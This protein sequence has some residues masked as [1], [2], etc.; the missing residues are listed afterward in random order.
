MAQ[1]LPFQLVLAVVAVLP[2]LVL[3]LGWFWKPANP[4]Q[5]WPIAYESYQLV[6][7]IVFLLVV[8]LAGTLLLWLQKPRSF[9]RQPFVVL[10]LVYLGLVLL[11]SA[12][13]RDDLSRF[14][15]W[16]GLLRMDGV[17]YQI[18]LVLVGILAYGSVNSQNLSR[19]LTF[20][21]L[22]GAA[23]GLLMLGQVNGIDPLGVGLRWAGSTLAFGSLAHPGMAAGLL[24]VSV[25]LAV[26]MLG[27][28]PR[29]VLLWIGLV[30]STLGIGYTTN[31]T[32]VLVLLVLLAG[33]VLTQRSWGVLAAALV[34]LGVLWFSGGSANLL[35]KSQPEQ[36]RFIQATPQDTVSQPNPLQALLENRTMQTRLYI[37]QIAWW[38]INRT[39]GQPLVGAGPD[40]LK[41]TIMRA[42]PTDLLVPLYALEQ[43]WPNYK[44]LKA[45]ANYRPGSPVRT[46]TLTVQFA[47]YGDRTYVAR[48]LG[49]SLDK[50][51][52]LFLD[53]WVNFGLGAMLIWLA[54]ML[55]PAWKGWLRP[56]SL[57]GTLA[58]TGLGLLGFYLF[59]FSVV[60]VEPLHLILLAAA[61]GLLVQYAPRARNT[62]QTVR[63]NK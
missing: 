14:V 5:Y 15:V 6:P 7:R 8:G 36:P 29:A 60:Q 56:R 42:P 41:L 18:S 13:T 43:A 2:L 50:S 62:T 47:E 54:L 26:G 37:W 52:N 45:F 57:E 35:A 34:S 11:S 59:W 53:R 58:W 38:A 46:T 55:V 4:V 25:S 10:L 28:Q 12:I 16:G 24:M 40:G 51:H 3:P 9:W 32:A 31:L 1:N 21:V 20:F 19:L 22:A 39:P 61:W 48:R 30:L 17:L 63:A 27:Q 49:L 23:Q 33:L 44:V